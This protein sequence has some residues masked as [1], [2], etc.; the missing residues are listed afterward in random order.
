MTHLGLSFHFLNCW[1]IGGFSS[2]CLSRFQYGNEG[3][4]NILGSIQQGHLWD[5]AQSHHTL[6]KLSPHFHR[7]LTT[8][9]PHSHRTL[10][11]LSPHSHHTLTAISSHFHRT[12]TALSSH[13]CVTPS[14]H[15]LSLY[16][17]P[18][19]R[20]HLTICIISKRPCSLLGDFCHMFHV[21]GRL[22]S[23]DSKLVLRADGGRNVLK[24]A[25]QFLEKQWDETIYAVKQDL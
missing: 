10:T 24:I 7:T 25:L 2:C 11:A 4:S 20:P 16:P 21:L 23:S 12:L 19:P 17:S 15:T 8:L 3:V 13:S 1:V 22:L 18:S 14:D 6:I 9:S 5:K